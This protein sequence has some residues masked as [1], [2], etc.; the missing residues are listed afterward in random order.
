MF[1]IYNRISQLLTHILLNAYSKRVRCRLA[2]MGLSVCLVILIAA[3]IQCPPGNAGSIPQHL[4]F[5]LS[6][7]LLNPS[8]N[9]WSFLPRWKGHFNDRAATSLPGPNDTVYFDAENN[10]STSPFQ[11]E[12]DLDVEIEELNFE[13]N[14]PNGAGTSSL[15]MILE[16]PDTNNRELVVQQDLEIRAVNSSMN[17]GGALFSEITEVE[18]NRMNISVSDFILRG[19]EER[20]PEGYS[21]AKLALGTTLETRGGVFLRN[22]RLILF[23][24]EIRMPIGPRNDTQHN[25]ENLFVDSNSEFRIANSLVKAEVENDGNIILTGG[26]SDAPNVSTFDG[27]MNSIGNIALANFAIMR[28]TASEPALSSIQG[29]ISGS[30][31]SRFIVDGQQTAVL[32]GNNTFEGGLFV[33]NGATVDALVGPNLGGLGNSLILDSGTMRASGNLGVG[34]VLEVRNE[35]AIDTQQHNVDL[36]QLWLGD[37]TLRK[38]GTGILS[39]RQNGISFTGKYVVEEGDLYASRTDSFAPSA[40]VEVQEHGTLRFLENASH[41]FLTGDGTVIIDAGR[42][43]SIRGNTPDMARESNFAGSVEGTGI[44]RKTGTGT[45]ILSGDNSSFGGNWLVLEGVLEFA[46]ENALVGVATVDNQLGGVLRHSGGG[47]HDG[48]FLGN[49]IVQKAGDN[50]LTLRSND[51]NF[52]GTYDIQEGTL[53]FDRA[54]NSTAGISIGSNG[55]LSKTINFLTLNTPITIAG[56]GA[57]I[58]TAGNTFNTFSTL[59]GSHNLVKDGEGEFWATSNANSFSG[60]VHVKEGS[61]AYNDLDL[62]ANSRLRIDSGASVRFGSGGSAS[63]GI[64]GSLAGNGTFN[65]PAFGPHLILGGDD[66]S[67]TFGG[68]FA[69]G[70]DIT[71]RGTGT[72]A[73][74]GDNGTH[75]GDWTVEAGTLLVA[76]PNA[77]NPAS[78]IDVKQFATLQFSADTTMTSGLISGERFGEVDVTNEARVRIQ[79]DVDG[80]GGTFAPAAGTVVFESATALSA[81][82]DTMATGAV[83]FDPQGA[84][85]TAT[86][87]G[88]GTGFVGIGGPGSLTLDTSITN[89]SALTGLVADTGDVIFN[90]DRIASVEFA[91]SLSSANGGNFRK[92]G[93]GRLVLTGDGSGMT[94][95]FFVDR[96]VVSFDSPT[97]NAINREADLFINSGTRASFMRAHE[98]GNITGGGNLEI[99]GTTLTTFGTGTSTFSG[100]IQGSGRIN[101]GGTGTW[102]LPGDNS[103]FTGQL[104]VNAGAVQL[105]GVLG[106]N[107]VIVDGTLGGNGTATGIVQVDPGGLISPGASAGRLSVGRLFLRLGSTLEIEIGGSGFGEFDQLV[108][109]GDADLMGSIVLTTLAGYEHKFGN[110]I[111]VVDIRGARMGE[112][113]GV[114][115]GDLLTTDSGYHFQIS[116][117]GGTGNDVVITAIPEPATWLLLF[118]CSVVFGS[119][120]S[121][122]LLRA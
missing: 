121:A 17:S 118:C 14:L 46:T 58:D 53:A 3:V 41:S 13:A 56:D 115:E 92:Q 65:I 89:F 23:D 79:S 25:F 83:L 12:F 70:S 38:R 96:G 117:L 78:N 20:N 84:D 16:S 18:F 71:K 77:V 2:R 82:I 94:G 108:V 49:G 103:G 1:L 74:S 97:F 122:R 114:G 40:E 51:S 15:R 100:A 90:E 42:T 69:G 98:V 86:Q 21:Q 48:T 62:L 95:T 112:F 45:Q 85:W 64:V 102:T 47:L 99:A 55:T 4:A 10:V 63:T 106:A 88:F 5:H 6:T 60:D 107:R 52:T 43:G 26:F 35:S 109:S 39:L 61:F 68:N 19:N 87:S 120:R 8:P 101:K 33:T 11:V 59:N 80:F 29:S 75:T 66:S 67:S 27:P 72:F 22:S 34:I 37:G 91:G 119:K 9:R 54:P 31:S 36:T 24:G 30:A 81:K 104:N 32:R 57:T 44:F 76:G 116:Y 111:R 50:T 93:I 113:F 28:L 105:D 110:S 7:D 73:V